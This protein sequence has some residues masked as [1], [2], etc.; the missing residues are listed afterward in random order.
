VRLAD[1][2]FDS[3]FGDRRNYE[4][5]QTGTDASPRLYFHPE[6]G[7]DM[8]SINVMPGYVQPGSPTISA[9]RVAGEPRRGADPHKFQIELDPGDLGCT[10]AVEFASHTSK[11]GGV[12]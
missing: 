11:T 10:V 6:V 1:Q 5:P 4:T 7:C 2:W 12:A 3:L 8:K 9:V